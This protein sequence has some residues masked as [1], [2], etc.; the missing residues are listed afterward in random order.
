MNRLKVWI[1]G[2]RPMTL[3]LSV[4]AVILGIGC[5]VP[6]L[7]K[8]SAHTLPLMLLCL[9]V[10]IALQVGV[11]FAN[12]YSDGVKGTDAKRKGPLRLVGSGLVAPKRVLAAAL[13]SFGI[14]ALAGLSIVLITHIW[15]LLIVGLFCIIA[16][17]FYT[18]GKHPY[19]YKPF[20]EVAVLVF[21]GIVPTALTAYVLTGVISTET[22]IAGISAGLFSAAVLLSNNIRDRENDKKQQKNTLAVVAGERA[23][24]IIY[25]ICLLL[26]FLGLI[27]F[28]IKTPATILVMAV[29][30]LIIVPTLQLFWSAR[31]TP[32]WIAVL[33]RT[34]LSALV[35]ELALALAVTYS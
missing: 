10:A 13:I 35:F 7:P 16:A 5:A 1:A 32:D 20:G 21:F 18:G 29:L 17:W 19:G 14:A 24:R 6:L 31:T 15:W 33:K 11:N 4:G 30:P 22:L 23:A 26:P 28:V 12:D 9:L 3:P 27:Y 34:L 8:S 2:S 25:T